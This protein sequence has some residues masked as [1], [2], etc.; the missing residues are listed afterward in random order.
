MLRQSWAGVSTLAPPPM[1]S[2]G[3]FCVLFRIGVEGLQWLQLALSFATT[4][5]CLTKTLTWPSGTAESKAFSPHPSLHHRTEDGAARFKLVACGIWDLES[6]HL[7]AP[8]GQAAPLRHPANL[9][10]L[11]SFRVVYSSFGPLTR[12]TS[13]LAPVRLC[14][15]YCNLV[16]TFHNN[17][18][19]GFLQVRISVNR[20]LRPAT[21]WL[22]K[23]TATRASSLLYRIVL[24]RVFESTI[25]SVQ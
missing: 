9:D 24:Q 12:T 17:I 15:L 5:L 10:P 16:Y 19:P 13:V 21:I 1:S 11:P 22:R 4:P 20:R 2:L 18:A 6:G 3:P 8:R 7:P 25:L 23:L 14:L